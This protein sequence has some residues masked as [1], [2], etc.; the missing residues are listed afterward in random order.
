MTCH[1]N[2]PLGKVLKC[3]KCEFRV[4]AGAHTAASTRFFLSHISARLLWS[5]RRSGGC[6]VVDVRRV[7]ERGDIRV[8]FGMSITAKV[9]SI[10]H[11][12]PRLADPGLS[13]VSTTFERWTKRGYPCTPGLLPSCSEANGEPGLGTRFVFSFHAGNH[14]YGCLASPSGG[15][16]QYYISPPLGDGRMLVKFH[17]LQF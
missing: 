2:G 10:Y 6:G 15:G 12:W 16:G 1:K 4:H 17:N 3:K 11:R 13:P 7:R 14:I 9:H 8:V 5:G